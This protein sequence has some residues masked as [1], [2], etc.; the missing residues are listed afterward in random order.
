M[1]VNYYFQVILLD[2]S[3]IVC[4]FILGLINNQSN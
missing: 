1:V 4:G 2:I 3:C